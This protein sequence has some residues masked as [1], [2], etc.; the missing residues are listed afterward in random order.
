MTMSKHSIARRSHHDVQGRFLGMPYDFRIPTLGKIVSRVA[1][2]RAGWL[3]PKPFGVGW[4]L[5]LAHPV[6]WGIIGGA[7]ALAAFLAFVV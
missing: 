2:P 7:F 4:T 1:N 6:S 3:A 5:N